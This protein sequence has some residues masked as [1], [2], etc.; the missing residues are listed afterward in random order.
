MPSDCADEKAEKKDT[1]ETILKLFG[2]G[3]SRLL[4]YSFGGFLAVVIA[5]K[6]NPVCTA[7]YFKSLG[8]QLAALASVVVGAGIYAAHRSAVIPVHHWMGCFLFWL[9]DRCNKTSGAA[10]LSPTRWFSSLGVKR[11]RRMLA[12]NVLR[13]DPKFVNDQERER[14]DLAHAEFGLVVMMA[15][16]SFVAAV[17]VSTHPASHPA[18]WVWF[19]V[20]VLLWAASYPGPLQ[21]HASECS[22]WRTREN[23]EK[24]DGFGAVSAVLKKHGLL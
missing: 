21:Q 7:E 14:L 22:H 10:S 20:G 12:Y 15:E 1:V 11:C 18:W 9:W 17:Y 2:L 4:R 16:G 23:N 19:S 8:W 6:V 3:L 5:A 13:R 24:T